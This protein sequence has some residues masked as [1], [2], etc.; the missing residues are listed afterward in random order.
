[1][2]QEDDF[3][4]S[5]LNGTEGDTMEYVKT[6]KEK[7]GYEVMKVWARARAVWAERR[8]WISVVM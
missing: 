6:R 1:M 2:N 5:I 4:S 7:T 8:D 3:S